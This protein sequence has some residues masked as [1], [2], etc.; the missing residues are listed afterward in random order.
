MRL[1]S[2]HKETII[3]SLIAVVGLA[4]AFAAAI[5]SSAARE[6][7]NLL[8]TAILA[9]AALLLSGVVAI[10]TVPYLTKRVAAERVRAALDYQITKE[11]MVYLGFV[12]VIAIA[13]LNTGNN[14][15]FLIVSALLAAVAVSGAAS[16][17]ELRALDLTANF[18][19][20]A[21][22]KKACPAHITIRNPSR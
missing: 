3:R 14:L 12:L 4:L 22:A 10:A 9:S 16:A 11:G 18:P 20:H 2:A 13:A 17:A 19:E 8:A 5:L 15:L 6:T 7:G 21:F 1:F